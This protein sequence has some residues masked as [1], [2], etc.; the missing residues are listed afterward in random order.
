M[1]G[2]G[3]PMRMKAYK[4]RRISMRKMKIVADSSCDLFTLK[5]VELA[6]AP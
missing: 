4:K 5:H 2:M 6:T 1:A 3:I